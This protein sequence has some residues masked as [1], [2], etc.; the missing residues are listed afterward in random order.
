M[1]G[2][3]QQQ[4]QRLFRGRFG[5]DVRAVMFGAGASYATHEGVTRLVDLLVIEFIRGVTRSAA[6]RRSRLR[7]QVDASYAANGVGYLSRS[8]RRES[9]RLRS[10]SSADPS[11]TDPVSVEAHADLPL[12]SEDI[13][14]V[15]RA[16]RD[17]R[18]AARAL[19][20]IRAWDDIEQARYGLP[21]DVTDQY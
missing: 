4:Q 2:A 9:R 1:A 19:Q 10:L 3:G 16:S 21:T 15:L 8:M 17:R 18:K 14:E 11:P 13:F 12:L 6:A 7:A 20:L 5:R